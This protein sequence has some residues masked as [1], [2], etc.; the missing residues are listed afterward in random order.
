M[1]FSISQFIYDNIQYKFEYYY[2]MGLFQN[3]IK[4]AET[5]KNNKSNNVRIKAFSGYDAIRE[6]LDEQIHC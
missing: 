3:E 4:I 2:N 6:K 1:V 5:H